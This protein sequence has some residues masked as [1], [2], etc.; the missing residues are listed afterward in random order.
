V[1]ARAWA[2][3]ETDVTK[4][5]RGVGKEDAVCRGQKGEHDS[6]RIAQSDR[7]APNRI[8]HAKPKEAAHWLQYEEALGLDTLARDQLHANNV[9]RS[10][11]ELN[12]SPTSFLYHTF[13]P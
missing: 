3:S 12:S 4:C 8:W 11:P 5:V 2:S 10:M 1:G 9:S 7:E 13:V 6:Y